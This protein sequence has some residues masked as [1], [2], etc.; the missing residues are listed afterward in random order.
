MTG[1]S[2][3][4][5]NFLHKVLLTGKQVLRLCK[6]FANDSSANINFSKNHLS[7]SGGVVPVIPTF[8]NILWSLVKR[9]IDI[10]RSF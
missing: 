3:D 8:G 5:T 9:V 6:A 2:N 10:F 7:E 1:D 4:G